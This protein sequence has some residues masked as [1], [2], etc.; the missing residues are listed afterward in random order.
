MG[1]P[2]IASRVSGAEEQLGD[3]ALLVDPLDPADIA[4]AIKKLHDEADLR[5][6]L[7]KRGRARASAWTVDDFVKGAFQVLDA[8]VPLRR[9]WRD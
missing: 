9:T 3:A 6:T 7:I 4:A 2:V 1:C 5:A 8:F